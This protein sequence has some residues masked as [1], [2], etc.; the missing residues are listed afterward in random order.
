MHKVLYGATAIE[1]NVARASRPVTVTDATLGHVEDV[2]KAAPG[3][4]NRAYILRQLK[5]MGA[6][7]NPPRLNRAL[8][9]FAQHDMLVEGSKGIQWTH[10]LSKSLQRAR[11]V[12]RRV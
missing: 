2:L 4:V 8:A 7:T 5:A 11:A 9:F 3:P 1:G 10:S 12:G 6:S